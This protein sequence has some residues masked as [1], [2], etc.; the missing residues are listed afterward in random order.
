MQESKT[1]SDFNSKLCDIANEAFA[2]GEKISEEKLVRKALRSLPQRFAYKVTA[3]EEAKDIQAMKLDELMGSLRTF[4]MN[5]NEDKKEKEI[6]LQAE[7]QKSYHEED[8]DDHKDLAESLDL[9]TK[10]FNRVMKKFNKKNQNSSYGNTSNR[11]LSYNKTNDSQR[12]KSAANNSK[13]KTK[14]RGIQCQGCDGYEHIQDECANT[15]KKKKK[16]FNTTWSD[17]ELEDSQEDDDHVSNYVAFN[18][19]IDQIDFADSVT[20]GAAD[21]VTTTTVTKL[22]IKEKEKVDS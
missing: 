18:V 22:I 10:N 7:V 15:L 4:E 9:L 19:Y 1:I 12:N 3:I 17:E 8:S 6:A 5:F 14:N 11:K 13:L 16:S 20:N 2:L 21:G